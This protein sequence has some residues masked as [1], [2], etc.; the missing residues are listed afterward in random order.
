MV[1]LH[2]REVADLP[3]RVE[4]ISPPPRPGRRFG[5]GIWIWMQVE[6]GLEIEVA[7]AEPVVGDPGDLPLAGRASDI[8][9]FSVPHRRPRR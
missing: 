5:R 4:A 9:D 3:E 2:T 7:D 6:R 1:A 8:E